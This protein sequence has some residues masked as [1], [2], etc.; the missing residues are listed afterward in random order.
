MQRDESKSTMPSGRLKSAFVGQTVTHGAFSQWLQR[1][2][3]KMAASVGKYAIFG[4]FDPG[5]KHPER[6]L[7]LRFT[8]GR[9]GMTTDTLPVVYDE[10]VPH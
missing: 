3:L 6:D 10:T 2:T 8:R 4:I 7:V 1:M 9:T 5:P